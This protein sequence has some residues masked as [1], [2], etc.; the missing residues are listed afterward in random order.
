[1]PQKHHRQINFKRA[2]ISWSNQQMITLVITRS[3]SIS[4]RLFL[5]GWVSNLLRWTDLRWINQTQRLHRV[6]FEPCTDQQWQCYD[7]GIHTPSPFQRV[8]HDHGQLF[9][10]TLN[11][12]KHAI[13]KYLLTGYFRLKYPHKFPR[14]WEPSFCWTSI[15]DVVK[16]CKA[17]RKALDAASTPDG[18]FVDGWWL[19]TDDGYCADGDDDDSSGGML[20]CDDVMI[21][22]DV[23]L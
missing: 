6:W 2:S 5:P 22:G 14:N 4:F 11:N 17:A 13:L 19:M 7:Y 18:M 23:A 15:R 9:V 16:W 21:C 10:Q 3:P 8:I 1:M 20:W 12:D